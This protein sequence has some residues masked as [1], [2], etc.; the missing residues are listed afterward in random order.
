MAAL[1]RVVYDGTKVVEKEFFVLTELLMRELLKL[2]GIEAV[3]ETKVQ[4]K[5]EVGI[6]AIGFTFS[7]LSSFTLFIIRTNILQFNLC[8]DIGTYK[9]L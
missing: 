4:R 7:S 1:E 8:M 3:G 5:M 2:D 9:H 6:Y